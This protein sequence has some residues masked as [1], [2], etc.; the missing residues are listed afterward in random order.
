MSSSISQTAIKGGDLGW[1][2]ENEISKK[3]KSI[4]FDTPIGALSEP[5]LLSD[6]IL[7]FKVRN[8]RKIIKNIDLEQLKNQLVN[9]EKT[10]MLNM[11]SRSH[12]DNLKR[13]IS[14]KY[15]ND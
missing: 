15:F 12:F 5:I 11:Y 14:I 9:N 3:F 7:I 4:I 1:L 2:N 8:K 10:K 6:G 13:S